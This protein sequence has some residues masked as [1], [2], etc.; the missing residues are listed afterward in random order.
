MPLSF[1][2]LKLGSLLDIDGQ[3]YQIVWQNFMRTAQRK[4]VLQAK[5]KNLITGKVMEYS[6]KF[7]EKIEEAAV[8]RKTVQFLYGDA[9][10]YN[11][12]DNESYE[13]VTLD[14]ELVGNAKDYLKAGLDCNLIT[15]NG[16]PIKVDVPV[17]VEYTIVSTVPGVKGDTATG[18]TKPATIE[19]GATVYV[20]L[21][22]K[23][24]EKIRVNTETGDYVER[25]NS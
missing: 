24:G 9:S 22:I 12:M 21:F 10:G 13:T 23:E 11:F 6:F 15:F 16:K 18:G 1:S 5:L 20:P 8:L 4:P 7:G 14:S 17:K 3:P 19:T 25:V 2:E